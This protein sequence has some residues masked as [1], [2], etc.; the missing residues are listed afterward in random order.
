MAHVDN[1]R[2]HF[3]AVRA[4]TYLNTG[5]FGAIPDVAGDC[6]KNLLELQVQEGRLQGYFPQLSTV[7]DQVLGHL[8]TLFRAPASSFAL[9]ESTTHG[10]NIVLWGLPFQ[11]GDEVV[12]TGTEHQA[13]ILPVFMQKQRRGI[14]V[15]KF[16]VHRSI[17]ETLA[18]L[19]RAL[20][21]RTRLVVCSHVSYE[22]GQRLPIERLAKRAHEVGALLLVDGAQGAGAEFID[23]PESGVDFYALPGQ[24][25][26]C[27]LDGLGALYIKP[28]L[29]D[30]LEQTYVGYPSLHAE[31]PHALYG[32][33]LP[34]DTT[35]RY[36]H[37]QFGLTAWAGWLESL[38]FIR[39]QVGW[40]YAFSR[41][42]GLSGHLLDMLLDIP[43]VEVVTPRES[44][45]GI[46]S[47]RMNG[48]PSERI[49]RAAQERNI[50]VRSIAHKDLVRVST[51]FYNAEDDVERL[52]NLV[53]RTDL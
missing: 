7:Q 32:Y 15:K 47:F 5:T 13:G 42:H 45:A 9:T 33:F 19:D 25:W 29:R 44:R 34:G 18:S 28:Q 8:A 41:I 46:V 12:Y 21:K 43:N 17:E 24:K 4:N 36:E 30:E 40:D 16:D 37:G 50:F 3:P 14:H 52:I 26:L 2:R 6:M 22:T 10:M 27:G 20:T 49:V 39:V 48:V 38:K 11:P 23:L 51:G 31:H 1:V 35:R 53:R